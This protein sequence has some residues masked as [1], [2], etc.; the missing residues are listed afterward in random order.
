M[1]EGERKVGKRAKEKDSGGKE[2]ERT[3]EEG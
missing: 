3:L 1:S 2:R